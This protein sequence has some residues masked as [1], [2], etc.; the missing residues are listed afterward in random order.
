MSLDDG[1]PHCFVC[2]S[3]GM[4][5]P[6]LCQDCYT[7]LNDAYAVLEAT[8]QVQMQKI[9]ELHAQIIRQSVELHP[10]PDTEIIQSL[11]VLA[12]QLK[13]YRWH[14]KNIIWAGPFVALPSVADSFA[15]VKRHCLALLAD[16]RRLREALTVYAD[17][18]NWLL[19]A[20]VYDWIRDSDPQHIAQA[21]LDAAG[22]AE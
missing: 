11:D 13:S 16:N 4:T 21:A 2:G 8:L 14:G 17:G 20:G 5:Q 12:I 15:A 18:G 6:V 9:D 19:G 1:C 7:G 3:Y 22:G 10:L